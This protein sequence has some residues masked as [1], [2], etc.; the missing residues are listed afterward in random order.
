MRFLR[1]F[2]AFAFLLSVTAAVAA[3]AQ[4]KA[5]PAVKIDESVTFSWPI[6]L[7]IVTSAVGYGMTYSKVISHIGNADIHLTQDV[8]SKEHPRREECQLKHTA[9]DDFRKEVREDLREIKDM[10]KR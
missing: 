8:V 7:L 6:V 2:F 9:F 3:W 5:A 4:A 1:P 10:L